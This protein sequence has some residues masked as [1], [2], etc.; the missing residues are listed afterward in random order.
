MEEPIPE[1]KQTPQKSAP[2]PAKKE[3]YQKPL[4]TPINGDEDPLAFM[5]QMMSD[6]NE[7]PRLRLD[8]AKA[9]APYVYPKQGEKGKTELKQESAK[10]AHAKFK[11]AAAPTRLKV[12]S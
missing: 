9:L 1:P 10:E 5:R 7:D 4:S 11:P 8:A 3:V 12:V 6:P 2:P